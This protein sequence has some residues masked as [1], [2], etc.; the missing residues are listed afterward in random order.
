LER[1]KVD[2]KICETLEDFEALRDEIFDEYAPLSPKGQR[3][4]LEVAKV[5]WLKRRL[6][7]Y[8]RL[9]ILRIQAARCFN[10][11][12]RKDSI[13]NVF[14]QYLCDFARRAGSNDPAINNKEDV[15]LIQL[16]E[17]LTY[18]HLETEVEVESKLDARL[19]RAWKRFYCNKAMQEIAGSK[20]SLP[21]PVI[22]VTP[23]SSAQSTN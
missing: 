9:K 20:K 22:D 18:G 5:Y 3:D 13:D 19:D 8:Q 6:Y 7:T 10:E 16:G 2:Q 1:D 21:G 4:L 23:N 14:Q 17:H 11:G 12:R 15:A